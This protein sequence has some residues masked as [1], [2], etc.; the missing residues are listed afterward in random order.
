MTES[1]LVAACEKAK[2]LWRT[3]VMSHHKE[4]IRSK[5]QGAFANARRVSQTSAMFLDKFSNE[6]KDHLQIEEPEVA[7]AKTRKA[8]RSSGATAAFL[9]GWTSEKEKLDH[10]FEEKEALGAGAGAG[11]GDDDDDDDDDDMPTI[12]RQ[13]AMSRSWDQYSSID[14]SKGFREKRLAAGLSSPDV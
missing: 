1:H 2:N 9:Q 8:R 11:A 12:P 3:R 6:R 7:R 13:R 14:A 10:E 4:K 5:L